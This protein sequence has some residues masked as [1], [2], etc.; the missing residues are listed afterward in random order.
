MQKLTCALLACLLCLGFT[1]ASAQSFDLGRGEHPIHVPGNYD[2]D[3]SVALIVLLHGYT[4]SG[5]GQEAYMQF[6]QHADEYG[7][8][9]V[10]PD[11]DKESA[12]QNNRFWN[13]SNAC[14]N[15]M[16]SQVDDSAYVLE[17]INHIKSRYNIDNKRVF[18][19]GHS[20]GG[21]MSYRAAYDHS[22]TI[23]A[24]ASIAGAAASVEQAPPANPVNILQIH[25]TDDGTI[26]YGGSDIQGTAYP[27]AVESVERWAAFNGCSPLARRGASMDLESSIDGAETTA[28]V[29]DTG[30]KAGG[31]TELWTTTGGPHVPRV[32]DSFSETIVQWLMAHPKS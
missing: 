25:G 7:F 14:C 8:I 9:L 27:S 1:N 3:E 5:A 12:G 24:I 2:Q 4:S 29:Y 15:F 13:A 21:F 32:S 28:T 31:S 23:A 18:L 20:N 17:I 10:S 30:C 6:A 11:G 26:A 22:G 19:V 16:D